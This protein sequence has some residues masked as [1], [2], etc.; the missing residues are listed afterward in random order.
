MVKGAVVCLTT[1][2][3]AMNYHY[4]CIEELLVLVGILKCLFLD[5]TFCVFSMNSFHGVFSLHIL[6]QFAA[7]KLNK[8][9]GFIDR[10]VCLVCV[11]VLKKL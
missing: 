1:V 7:V 5:G 10:A 6:F 2:N 9:I 4:L 11:N 3:N 8:G